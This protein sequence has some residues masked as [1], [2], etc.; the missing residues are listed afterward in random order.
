MNLYRFY[1]GFYVHVLHHV[2]ARDIKV[3]GKHSIPY[4]KQIIP[5]FDISLFLNLSECISVSN[6]WKNVS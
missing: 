4:R 3:Y 6:A 5:L 2:V 1:H